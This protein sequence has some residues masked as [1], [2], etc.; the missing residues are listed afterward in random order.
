MQLRQAIGFF[1]IFLLST[2]ALAVDLALA[3]RWREREPVEDDLVKPYPQPIWANGYA[4]CFKKESQITL[5]LI[6]RQ[7]DPE[8]QGW[9]VLYAE[10]RS[11]VTGVV[12]M[13]NFIPSPLLLRGC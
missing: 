2:F 9:K 6:R 1:L 5:R 11:K 4:A 13:V 8:V 10:L 3:L 12:A 7:G